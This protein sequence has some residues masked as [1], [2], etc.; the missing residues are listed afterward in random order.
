MPSMLL[1]DLIKDL[2][3]MVSSDVVQRLI[4]ELDTD[5]SAALTRLLEAAAVEL[6]YDRPRLLDATLTLVAG[7]RGYAAPAGLIDVEQSKW[8]VSEQATRDPWASNYPGLLPT[9][10]LGEASDGTD[11][12]RI[13]PAPTAAQI[14][15]LGAVYQY[16]YKAAH[17]LSEEANATTVRVKDRTLL[18]IRAVVLVLFEVAAYASMQPV[19]VGAHAVGA[20]M[21]K[22]GTPAAL[23]D[24]AMKIYEDMLRARS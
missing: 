11:E 5:G 22:N 9:L 18:L 15:D 3:A 13:S 17:V 6:S 7:Q 14:A 20:G 21:P 8:G 1:S 4:N 19:T 24:A 12:I 23:A 2:T 10:L 16:T